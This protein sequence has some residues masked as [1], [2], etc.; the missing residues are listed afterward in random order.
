MQKTQQPP[1]SDTVIP[2][3]R[4]LITISL[5]HRKFYTYTPTPLQAS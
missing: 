3:K 1:G 2:T 5:K 4:F